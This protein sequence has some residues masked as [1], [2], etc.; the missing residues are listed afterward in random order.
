M[1]FTKPIYSKSEVL[2]LAGISSSQFNNW[3]IRGLIPRSALG[4][5]LVKIT[6]ARYSALIPAY[7]RLITYHTG[8]QRKPYVEM[9]KKVFKQ[10]A[11]QNEFNERMVIAIDGFGKGKDCGLFENSQIAFRLFSRQCAIVPVGHIIKQHLEE[12][13]E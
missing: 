3:M 1:S 9:L 13:N 8:P 12:I 11:K 6:K 4:F 10:V 2:K 7:C 5:E